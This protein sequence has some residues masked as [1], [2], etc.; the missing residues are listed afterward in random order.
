MILG[1]RMI[2]VNLSKLKREGPQKV[3]KATA[4]NYVIFKPTIEANRF[5]QL[6]EKL[7]SRCQIKF[8]ILGC[9]NF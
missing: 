3:I 5:F 4:N 2:S 1:R 9:A 7:E 8:R 6:E